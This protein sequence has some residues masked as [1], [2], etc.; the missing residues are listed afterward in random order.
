MGA[1][2]QLLRMSCGSFPTIVQEEEWELPS[3]SS[4]GG[5]GASQLLLRRKSGSCPATT[6]DEE[7]ELPNNCPGGGVGAPLP[8]HCPRGVVGASQQ[9]LKRIKPNHQPDFRASIGKAFGR[10]LKENP[11]P[12]SLAWKRRSGTTAQEEEWELPNSC[13]GGGVGASQLL[14]TRWNGSLPR[15]AQEEEWELPSNCSGEGVGAS[16]LL[17]KSGSESFPTTAPEEEWE[18]PNTCPGGGGEEGVGASL[19]S[20]SVA[21]PSGSGT[22]R[23]GGVCRQPIRPSGCGKAFGRLLKENPAPRN[24]TGKKR[25]LGARGK[26]STMVSTR[27]ARRDGNYTRRGSKHAP[28]TS[29]NSPKACAQ[30]P[31]NCANYSFVNK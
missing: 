24:L 20:P 23:S 6:Q 17:L 15:I 19:A 3:S 5:M 2:Q 25:N 12:G 4:G 21:Y 7:W 14:L 9:L 18:L 31:C 26:P 1:S 28:W 22:E 29:D 16:Q 10:I 11:A 27:S 8:R 13:P 30:L